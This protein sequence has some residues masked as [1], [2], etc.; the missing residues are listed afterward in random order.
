MALMI[1]SGLA[2]AAIELLAPGLIELMNRE[3]DQGLPPVPS[4]FCEFHGISAAHLEDT[5][6]M[7]RQL[8]ADCGADGF[9]HAAEEKARLYL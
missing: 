9:N 6:A 8:C 1:G 3:K 7:A 4:L 5:A 2:P